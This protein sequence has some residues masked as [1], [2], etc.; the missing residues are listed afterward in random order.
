M[1]RRAVVAGSFYAGTRERLQ[2]QLDELFLPGEARSDILAAIVPHAG[3]AY[4]GRVAAQVYGR[5]APPDSWVICGPNHTGAGA[6]A[7]IL[8]AGEWE[9]PL[10]RMAIDVGLGQAILARSSVLREDPAAHAQEHSIEVQL[11]FMQRDAPASRFVPIALLSH[12]YAVCRDVGLALAAAIQDTD[13]R[14][15]L[16][17][18]SDMSHYVSRAVATARDRQALD[19]ILAFDPE[20]LHR[21]VCHEGIS[22]CGFHATTAVLVA[23][24][25]LGA[26]TAEL[27]TYTDSGA[28]TGDTAEVVAYAGL[29]IR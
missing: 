6:R 4:S 14:V 25:A 1:M 20:G 2:T 24:K 28:V 27:V 16:V 22:M 21:V 13:R 12:E 8:T 19:A 10:G 18:S 15:V 11:P 29:I 17:A 5:I 3:Y 7:A 26:T 9:T 23:A